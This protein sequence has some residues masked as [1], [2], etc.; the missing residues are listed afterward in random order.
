M[1]ILKSL[2]ICVEIPKKNYFIR[3][4]MKFVTKAKKRKY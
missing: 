2:K 4:I 3:L 1:N